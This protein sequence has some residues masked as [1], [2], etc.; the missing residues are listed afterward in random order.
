M[1]KKIRILTK[2]VIQ[3]LINNLEKEIKEH[4]FRIDKDHLVIE[5]YAA[6]LINL[7]KE[8]EK[9]LAE[10]KQKHHNIRSGAAE[11]IDTLTKDYK[12]RET[13]I[14]TLESKI[15]DC[16]SIINQLDWVEI[17]KQ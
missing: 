8:I 5:K 9:D 15:K 16:E 12:N 7:P 13:K 1:K 3:E 14:T 2:D 4:K 17:K 11:I 10:L 6:D